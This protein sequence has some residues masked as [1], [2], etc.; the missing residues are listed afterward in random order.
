[1]ARVTI[2]DAGV[3]TVPAGGGDAAD[4]APGTPVK[5]GVRPEKI[6]L[7]RSDGAQPEGWNCISGRLRVS[8]FIGVSH[9]YTIDGPAGTT[10]TVYEQNLG[11]EW[12]PQAGDEVRLL[13]RPDH[14]FVVKPSAPLADWEEEP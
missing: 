11:A 4:A 10:I 12:V 3:I 8:T 9:Q 14:T 2:P 1:M 7:E 6:R 13:W 5:V